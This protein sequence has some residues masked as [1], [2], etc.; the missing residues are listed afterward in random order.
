MMETTTEKGE[1]LDDGKL[2][3]TYK[4]KNGEIGVD[5]FD[6][7][8]VATGRYPDTQKLNCQEIGI[9][10]AKSGKIIVDS[11]EKSSVDTIFA[12]GDVAEGKLELTPPAIKA[13]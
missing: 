2:R 12:I 13:G 4:N 5:D 3:I 10:L 6:S 11:H 8:L 1:K 7:V 9:A